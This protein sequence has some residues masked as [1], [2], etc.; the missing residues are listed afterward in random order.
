MKRAI[1]CI[2]LGLVSFVSLSAQSRVKKVEDDG[3]VWYK[4]SSNGYYG[5]ESS[6]GKTLVPLSKG[7]TFIMYTSN[8]IGCLYVQKDNHEG[9]Y[10]KDG[11][12]LISTD[13]AYDSVTLYTS[14]YFGVKK[15]GKEGACDLSGKEVV[16]PVY[17]DLI[18]SSGVY[19]TKDSNGNWVPIS[20]VTVSTTYHTTTTNTTS[21]ISRR[22]FKN[23]DGHEGYYTK[24]DGYEGIEDIYGNTVIPL[25]RQYINV[26]YSGGVYYVK[27]DGYEGICD[28]SGKE[29]LAPRYYKEVLFSSGKCKYKNTSGEW[30]DVPSGYTSTA[31]VST[32]ETGGTNQTPP[33][34]TTR[35]SA[36]GDLLYSGQYTYTS[37][38]RTFDDFL[39]MGTPSLCNITV[40]ERALL[41]N[42]D[43]PA[44]YYG[45]RT[46]YGEYGRA[47]GNSEQFYLVTNNGDIRYVVRVTMNTMLGAF[48]DERMAFFDHGDTRSQYEG[49]AFSSKGNTNNNYNTGGTYGG[50]TGTVTTQQG[51]KSCPVCYGTGTCQT[52][53]GSGWV[54]NPYSNERHTCS[55]CNNQYDNAPYKGKCWKCHGT[56]R[57]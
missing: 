40:Y 33:S 11:R 5:A 13:R 54:S 4:L 6:S 51:Q 14:G 21:E 8:S 53:Y 47:Y 56:G 29:I 22:K 24:K 39:G 50:S 3:F 12:E 1:I 7:Y 46:V 48:T 57:L 16:P 26:L 45:Y 55:S 31:T 25:S 44:E 28:K 30:I 35:Q 23:D 43:A 17:S 20:E 34:S 52:C 18:L 36:Y 42:N 49:K 38:I 41:F 19:N 32:H 10:S 9:I 37:L 27:K 15:N 2:L